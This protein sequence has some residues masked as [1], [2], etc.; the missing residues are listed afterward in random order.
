M[1]EVR[2]NIVCKSG[3]RNTIDIRRFGGREGQ[4]EENNEVNWLTRMRLG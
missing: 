2:L 1:G 3:S 4:G